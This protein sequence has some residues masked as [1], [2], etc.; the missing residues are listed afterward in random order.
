MNCVAWSW[1]SRGRTAC[2]LRESHLIQRSSE[3]SKPRAFLSALVPCMRRTLS[4][5]RRFWRE[6]FVLGTRQTRAISR[7]EL[8]HT[9]ASQKS[10]SSC[11]TAC[12]ATSLQAAARA[13]HF[14]ELF[15]RDFRV[16]SSVTADHQSR[17]AVTCEQTLGM[18]GRRR[19]HMRHRVILFL[20]TR[21]C[22]QSPEI[23]PVNPPALGFSLC[24]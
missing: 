8:G 18:S 4:P 15:N 23:S 21:S 7:V 17:S 12:F 13:N 11:R 5:L 14:S 6:S 3:A 22:P 16:C 19:K 20:H 1:P 10:L 9:L 2:Q 24:S